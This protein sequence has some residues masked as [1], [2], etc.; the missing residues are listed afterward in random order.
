MRPLW[1]LLLG[2]L[3]IGAC[4]SKQV[5][6]SPTQVTLHIT[7]SDAT[8]LAQLTQLHVAAAAYEGAGW[9][10]PVANLFD[11]AALRW[12]VDVPI[13]PRNKSESSKQFEVV[14]EALHDGTVFAQARVIAAFKPGRHVVLEVALF[15]CPEPNAGAVCA[16]AGCHG[17]ECMVC[18]AT[19]TCVPTPVLTANDLPEVPTPQSE[20]GVAPDAGKVSDG[21]MDAALRDAASDAAPGDAAPDA[22]LA[23]AST[24]AASSDA[25]VVLSECDDSARPCLTGYVCTQGSCVSACSQ[26]RCDPNATCSLSAGTPVCT[27]GSAYVTVPGDA[28][29]PSCVLDVACSEL[30]CDTNATCETGANQLRRCVCKPGY[31]GN[32]S[33][34]APVSCPALSKPSNGTISRTQGTYG[35]TAI[36]ACDVGYDLSAALTRTCE[37]TGKWSGPSADP[38]CAPRSCASLANPA[39]GVVQ[40]QGGAAVYGAMATYSCDVDFTRSGNETR[41]CQAN[42]T[43]TGTQPSCLGCGDGVISTIELGEGCD[44]K[45]PS[46]NM[47]TCN[48]STCQRA[49]SYS[50]CDAN[51]DS[52]PAQGIG[53]AGGELC[54]A[55]CSRTCSTVADC[56]AVP[57]G[58]SLVPVCGVQLPVCILTGCTTSADCP[59]GLL[60]GDTFAGKACTWCNDAMP[61]PNGQCQMTIRNTYTGNCPRR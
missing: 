35:Q 49:T 34:C 57:K 44:P 13:F 33:S 41:T 10:D 29:S 42:G 4:E 5:V 18:A 28:G 22:A 1:L 11:A 27:C 50:P 20:A 56:P 30:G 54:W 46:W 16:A 55:F 45:H 19:G 25:M 2:L 23:E 52:Q 3:L 6:D 12:P 53:C 7:S 51:D 58:S 59:P 40:I 37:V 60:C 31:T 39:H 9:R 43:W 15:R 38:T 48:P 36:Y 14:V 17:Q 24:D 32:G 8:L 61:C 26:T 47:W 21:G